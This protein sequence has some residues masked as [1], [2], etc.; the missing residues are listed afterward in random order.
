MRPRKA[1]CAISEPF[2]I[3]I[4]PLPISKSSPSST[5]SKDGK[6]CLRTFQWFLQFRLFQGLSGRVHLNLTVCFCWCWF[7]Y[8]LQLVL[9]PPIHSISD[10]FSFTWLF[11][12][13]ITLVQVYSFKFLYIWVLLMAS[14][15]NNCK[16]YPYST[17]KRVWRY[18]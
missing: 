4:R 18:I 11:D 1:I 15:C 5:S 10:L 3:L 2:Y 16:E 8:R 12:P 17:S 13:L 14:K 9:W 6:D 7:G